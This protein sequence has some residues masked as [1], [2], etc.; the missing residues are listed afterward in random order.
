MD[1]EASIT[2]ADNAPLLQAIRSEAKEMERS[3]LTIT[4]EK[5]RISLKVKAKDATAL[6]ASLNSILKLLVVHEKM[7][8]IR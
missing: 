4:E 6:R 3:S 5:G 2:I 1:L 7:E 8:G